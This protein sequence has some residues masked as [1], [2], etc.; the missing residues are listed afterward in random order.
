MVGP[1]IVKTML[2]SKLGS[3]RN[4][5]V[6]V[7]DCDAHIIYNSVQPSCN[8]LLL[9]TETVIVKIYKYLHIITVVITE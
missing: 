9:K 3:L 5:N 2:F 1:S 7:V 8:I 4:I 6:L